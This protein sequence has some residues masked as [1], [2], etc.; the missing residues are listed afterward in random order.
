[1]NA[2]RPN[3][4][5]KI[6]TLL[7]LLCMNSRMFSYGESLMRS[8]SEEDDIELERKVQRL[9]KT[10]KK[11]FQLENGR[12]I[13]CIDI[14]KQPTLDH[15]SLK[16]HIVQRKPTSYAG[17]IN[18]SSVKASPSPLASTRKSC[19]HG[20]VPIQRTT[21]DDLLKDRNITNAFIKAH[22]NINSTDPLKHVNAGTPRLNQA[23]EDNKTRGCF[24]TLCEGFV[25]VDSRISPGY[26]IT[27]ASVYN[28]DPLVEVK[29][30]LYEDPETGNW[31]IVFGED[32]IAVGYYP[33]DFVDVYGAAS[34][35]W[36]GYTISGS[37][38]ITPPLGSGHRPDHIHNHAAYYRDMRFIKDNLAEEI[39]RVD[40][41]TTHVGP[42]CHSI[43][44]L[45]YSGSPK[46]GYIFFYG[47]PG[48]DCVGT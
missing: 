41:L 10:P 20:T 30:K 13:D 40:E 33:K 31:W 9:N 18:K 7:V 34:M 3:M 47:G 8:L 27:P 46:W 21:K 45:H 26:A 16:N 14:N 38:G 37:D 2:L 23:E 42:N 4:I 6:T 15:P 39:P 24:N 48:G 28:G 17:E 43:D 19:P 32:N 5:S 25:Q 36:E 44:D 29:I 22:R 35:A 1:M 11:S 12:T